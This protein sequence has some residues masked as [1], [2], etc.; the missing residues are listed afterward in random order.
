[1]REKFPGSMIM[2]AIA[3]AAAVISVS[4]DPTAA[5]APADRAFLEAPVIPEGPAATIPA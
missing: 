3:A 2:V 5:Q 1:M 4:V